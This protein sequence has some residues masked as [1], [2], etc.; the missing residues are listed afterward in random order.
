MHL[1]L[2]GI[3]KPLELEEM[4]RVP[5]HFK[6]RADIDVDAYVENMVPPE[7]HKLQPLRIR[8]RLTRPGIFAEFIGLHV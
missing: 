7:H 6:G 4:F 8:Y 5:L 1:M 3:R 2:F